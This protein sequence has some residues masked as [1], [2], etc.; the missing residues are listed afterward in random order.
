M[1]NLRNAYDMRSHTRGDSAQAGVL[2]PA[3]IDQF[4]RR[5]IS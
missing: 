5:G 4:R 3:F 1:R 2:T